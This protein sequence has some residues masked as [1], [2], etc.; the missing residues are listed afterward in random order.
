MFRRPYK[1]GRSLATCGALAVGHSVVAAFGVG[2]AILLPAASEDCSPLERVVGVRLLEQYP[3]VPNTQGTFLPFEELK[4]I[5][6]G[7]LLSLG[8]VP[9]IHLCFRHICFRH[10]LLFRASPWL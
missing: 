1:G 5:F 7:V 10:K 4:D 3:P 9:D 2:A 8:E 6:I